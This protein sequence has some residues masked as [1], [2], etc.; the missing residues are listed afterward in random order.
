M[1]Y[2]LFATL[3]NIN[4]VFVGRLM[5]GASIMKINTEKIR[6]LEEI[7]RFYCTFKTIR[8]FFLMIILYNSLLITD[9]FK[10]F[11]MTLYIVYWLPVV[12][13]F[14]CFYNCNFKAAVF[15]SGF[16][17]KFS[18]ILAIFFEPHPLLWAPTCC[19]SAYCLYLSLWFRFC[20]PY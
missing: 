4:L 3:L 6:A 20:L 13:W 18:T 15:L 8:L 14:D 11:E 5:Q 16:S 7:P 9:S 2:V 12:W 19:F 1:K 10:L 17:A